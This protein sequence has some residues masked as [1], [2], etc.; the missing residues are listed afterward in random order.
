MRRDS[1]TASCRAIYA[2][3]HGEEPAPE[4]GYSN[5]SP[6]NEG[7]R[8]DETGPR[9]GCATAA[10]GSSVDRIMKTCTAHTPCSA[11]ASVARNEEPMGQHLVRNAV[12]CCRGRP[13]TTPTPQLSTY[14]EVTQSIVSSCKEKP[15]LGS[16][17]DRIAR[18]A[19]YRTHMPPAA[20]FQAQ[21]SRCQLRACIPCVY[22]TEHAACGVSSPHISAGRGRSALESR[23]SVWTR[24]YRPNAR[25]LMDVFAHTAGSYQYATFASVK[26]QGRVSFAP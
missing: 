1:R 26:L 4:Q 20:A 7:T 16:N 5:G 3:C 14:A 22:H 23:V 10:F 24:G 17:R 12:W 15:F 9:R 25:V 8:A 13:A 11:F 2:W 6:P 18:L 19:W 21:S